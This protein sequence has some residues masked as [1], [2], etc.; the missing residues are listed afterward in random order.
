MY[1]L[2]FCWNTKGCLAWR[3]KGVGASGGERL[4]FVTLEDQVGTSGQKLAADFS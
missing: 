3:G 4:K 1:Q 2:G